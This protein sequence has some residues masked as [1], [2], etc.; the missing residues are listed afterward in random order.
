MLPKITKVI[1]GKNRMV[2]TNSFG[3]NEETSKA[4]IKAV[5][6]IIMGPGWKFDDEAF[7]DALKSNSYHFIDPDL[8]SCKIRR[9]KKIDFIGYYLGTASAKKYSK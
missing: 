4:A 9:R 1:D 6:K 3:G 8:V 7:E 2:I 5:I